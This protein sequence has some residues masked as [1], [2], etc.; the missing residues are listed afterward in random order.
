MKEE[1]TLQEKYTTWRVYKR[2]K[3]ATLSTPKAMTPAQALFYFK[4]HFVQAVI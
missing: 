1:V 2:G 3:E 4:A